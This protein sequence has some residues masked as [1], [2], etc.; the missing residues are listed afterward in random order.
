MLVYNS[1]HFTRVAATVEI[2]MHDD[3]IDEEDQADAE[4]Y[5]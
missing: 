4:D 1:P 2:D 3:P 5:G